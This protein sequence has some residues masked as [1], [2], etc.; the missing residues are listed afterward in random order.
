[1][2]GGASKQQP[3]ASKPKPA[4]NNDDAAAGETKQQEGGGG[5]GGSFKLSI[6]EDQLNASMDARRKFYDANK[7][8]LD[9]FSSRLSSG[10]SHLARETA[11]HAVAVAA[12]NAA[13]RDKLTY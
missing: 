11:N 5:P 12:A 4:N 8:D 1:M 9:D 13:E 3:A 2:G 7:P 6:T 10:A